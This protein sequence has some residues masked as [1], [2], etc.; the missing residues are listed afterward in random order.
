MIV[1]K[2]G[3]PQR[4]VAKPGRHN[5]TPRLAEALPAPVRIDR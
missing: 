3:P 1:A 2:R 4:D 5:R